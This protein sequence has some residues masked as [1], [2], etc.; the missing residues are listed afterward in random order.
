ML[1]LIKALA[2][3]WTDGGYGRARALVEGNRAA[4]KA[5]IAPIGL[6]LADPASQISVARIEL[7][8]GG[9]D[10]ELLYQAMLE[11]GVHVLPCAPFHWADPKEGRRFIRLSLG[12]P[13]E[14]VA[15]GARAGGDVPATRRDGLLRT[16]ELG[17]ERRWYPR[18]STASP[19]T[20]R[21]LRSSP[22]RPTGRQGGRG[23]RAELRCGPVVS[24][25]SS[26]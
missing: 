10:S 4:V 22:R 16:A 15:A 12:R 26:P 21:T 5:A 3:D 6:E 23:G 14:V 19:A 8:A 9:P 24:W 1:Q 2:A 20:R 7:P 25:W 11:R 17:E 18:P 13:A